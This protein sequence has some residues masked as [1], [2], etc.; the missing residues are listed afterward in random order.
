MENPP[1]DRSPMAVA[2][3]WASRIMVVAMEMVLPGLGGLWIDTKL[4]TR[5]VFALVGFAAGTTLAILHLQR[6]TSAESPTSGKGAVGQK[7]DLKQT[8]RTGEHREP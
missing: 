6:M 7:P 3:E 5:A 8:G 4:G 2:V 1:E